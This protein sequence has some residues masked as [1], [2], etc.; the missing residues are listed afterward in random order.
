[1][2]DTERFIKRIPNKPVDSNSYIIQNN[3]TNDCLVV[4]PGTLD[5]KD[6]IKYMDKESLVPEYIILTHEH[7]DHVWGV[8]KLRETFGCKVI[9]SAM[10]GQSITERKRNLSIFYNQVGFECGK[11]DMLIEEINFQFNWRGRLVSFYETPGHSR[12]SISFSVDGI[13][14]TGDTIIPGVYT[15]LKLPGS[16]KVELR[17]SIDKIKS[18][19]H[20]PSMIMPGHGEPFMITTSEELE[21]LELIRV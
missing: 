2:I 10:C 1:M 15:V 19:L 8:E 16:D 17:K 12:G 18:L 7:F 6:L 3:Q 5:C 9:C 11:P 20:Y 4:D 13:V 14:F 21:S